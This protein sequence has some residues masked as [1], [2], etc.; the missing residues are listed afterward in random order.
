[1]E[2][3]LVLALALVLVVLTI[4]GACASVRA[5]T[6]CRKQMNLVDQSP[7]ESDFR[8]TAPADPRPHGEIHPALYLCT[9]LQKTSWQGV[10]ISAVRARDCVSQPTAGCSLRDAGLPEL[11]AHEPPGEPV[12]DTP[13]SS[14]TPHVAPSALALNNKKRGL[15]IESERLGLLRSRHQSLLAV[16]GKILKNHRCQE[17]DTL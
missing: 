1:M 8:A 9:G 17:G 15:C 14:F 3:E 2:L 6:T 13:W 4:H 16:F 7:R 5:R 10:P 11:W 12:V